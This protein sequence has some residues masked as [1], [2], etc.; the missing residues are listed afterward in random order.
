MPGLA[1]RARRERDVGQGLVGADV[2]DQHVEG[3]LA[4]GLGAVQQGEGRWIGGEHL[5]EQTGHQPTASLV[6]STTAQRCAAY[7]TVIMCR[8]WEK[9]AMASAIRKVS[10]SWVKAS[11]AVISTPTWP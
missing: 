8:S 7:S 3:A 9:S 1:V 2:P 6:V 10:M 5:P 4:G 11:T